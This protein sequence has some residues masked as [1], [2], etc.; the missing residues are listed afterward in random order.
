[1]LPIAAPPFG[2]NPQ[3]LLCACLVQTCAAFH[4]ICLV[5]AHPTPCW[6]PTFVCNGKFIDVSH[7]S[8]IVHPLNFETGSP[9]SRL[10]GL[11]LWNS[12]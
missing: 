4:H 11:V 6:Y 1:M 12:A 7:D 8:V 2:S 9:R 5:A 3:K 10:S